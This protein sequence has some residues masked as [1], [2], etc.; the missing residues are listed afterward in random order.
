MASDAVVEGV[1]G[2]AG[3]IV[4]LLSTYP[5]MTISTMQAT[6]GKASAGSGN[7]V[8]SKAR[9]GALADIAEAVKSVGVRGL[10]SGLQPALLG[11][12]VSQGVYFYLYSLLRDLAVARKHAA[13]GTSSLQSSREQELPIGASLLV[14]ALAGAGN[15]LLT[16]PIWV[17]ATRMQSNRH[18][19]LV[20]G[21][22]EPPAG[23]LLVA[24]D[25]AH[26][27]GVLGFWKGVLPALVMVCNPT[28]QYVLFEW[29]LAR[30]RDARTKAGRKGGPTAGQIFGIGAVAKLGATVM[31]YPLLLVKS[32][33]MSASATTEAAMRYSGTWD[34]LTRILHEDGFLG[35]YRGLRAKIVQSVLAAAIL[36]AVREKLYALTQKALAATPAVKLAKAK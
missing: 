18:T 3:G 25:I 19:K 35:F 14:A 15:V 9:Q 16:N 17:V 22:A 12:A 26:T 21:D 4:A 10:F 7:A 31:T 6:R 24:R 34:A 8:G 20:P 5:L 13:A 27:D 28:V 23:P 1:S 29:L 11:T 32:R 33:L 30:L 2:A 36:F